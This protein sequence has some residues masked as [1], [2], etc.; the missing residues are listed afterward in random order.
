M[1]ITKKYLKE[2]IKEELLKETEDYEAAQGALITIGLKLKNRDTKFIDNL[3]QDY[4]GKSALEL[5]TK[6]PSVEKFLK[7]YEENKTNLNNKAI[8]RT[9][10]ELC[11][12]AEEEVRR[13]AY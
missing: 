11:G 10:E 9:A 5:R 13:L 12:R 3:F 8:L 4:Y 1:K 7:F 2:I 6:V